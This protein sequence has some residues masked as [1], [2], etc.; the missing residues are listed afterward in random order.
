MHI[1]EQ[2]SKL[3]NIKRVDLISKEMALKEEKE[4]YAGIS[5]S[6]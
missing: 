6:H 4:R 1:A 3:D 5:R 2:V